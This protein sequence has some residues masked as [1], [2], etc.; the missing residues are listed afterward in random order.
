MSLL[1]EGQ[2]LDMLCFE[3]NYSVDLSA[4]ELV[5]CS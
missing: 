1:L 4:D 5:E 3:S 2:Y